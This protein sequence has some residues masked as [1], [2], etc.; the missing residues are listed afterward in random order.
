MT[1]VGQIEKKTQA[2]VVALFRDRLGYDYRGDWT[3]REGYE[4]KGNRNIEPELL[5]TWLQERGVDA[6]LINRALFELEKVAGDTSRPLYDRN[7]EVYRLLRYG[8]KVSPGAGQN[9]VT[10]WLVDWKNPMANHFAIA[11]EVTVRGADTKSSTKRP[12]VVIYVNGIALGL[13]E[14]KRSTVAVAEGIRQNLDNQ[15]KAFIQP[16]F[17]TMQWLMAGNDTEGLRY[18]PIQTPEKYWPKGIQKNEG[19]VAETI[20]NN[21]RKLIIDESPVNPADYEKMSKLL[22][23]LIKQR[24]EGAVSYKEYLDQIAALTRLA[25]TPGGAASAY[26]AALGTAAKRALYDN[27]GKDIALALKVDEAMMVSRMDDWR[28]KTAGQMAG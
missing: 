24:R 15:T 14:L 27:L 19:S 3:D 12:D 1:T 5:R 2:R 20:E 21:V 6:T 22:D 7:G 4:G 28:G 23:A 9:D 18:A 10:V 25:T 8:V 26:P 13:L 16:F 17:S 11:E